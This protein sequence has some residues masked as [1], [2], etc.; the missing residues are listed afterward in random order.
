MPEP[1]LSVRGADV[2]E[3]AH[4]L[5]K[6]EGR[7]VRAVVTDALREY[8][9]RHA[10]ERARRDED[11]WAAFD[12]IAARIRAEVDPAILMSESEDD[13]YDEDGLPT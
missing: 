10:A 5:A 8:E 7:T 4:R 3:M 1:Q 6:A 13:Y 11:R 9:A 12:R 2:I